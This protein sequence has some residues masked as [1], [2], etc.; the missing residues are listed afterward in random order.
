[1]A[2]EH[3]NEQISALVDGELSGPEMQN[4]IRRLRT[5]DEERRCWQDYH[6]IG[7]ALRSN[8]PPALD[9][10]LAERVS[11]TIASE[12]V[13]H[14]IPHSEKAV[15]K[16]SNYTRPAAGFAVAASVAV[17]GF[18]GFT[19]IVAED[20]SMQVASTASTPVIAMPV[21]EQN[22]YQ[23]VHGLQWTA[24]QPAIQS[25]LN[26]YLSDHQHFSGATVING[27]TVPRAQFAVETQA[28]NQ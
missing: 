22:Q 11:A 2:D 7:D 5:S 3:V 14:V 16:T 17:M 19:M 23:Q 18:V 21:A 10:R 24:Q 1:M 8:L 25:R 28:Y 13:L 6:L 15:P 27:R 12:P 26:A 9:N 4:V 20:Q